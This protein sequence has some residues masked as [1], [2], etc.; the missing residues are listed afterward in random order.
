[1]RRLA[2]IASATI[3]VGAVCAAP[4]AR[5]H[6]LVAPKIDRLHVSRN[7]V[8]IAVDYAVEPAKAGEMRAIFD[9]DADGAITG[10]ERDAAQAWLR[11]AA[12]AFLS[13]NVDGRKLELRE[14]EVKFRGLDAKAGD[15]GGVFVL[16]SPLSL[17]PGVHTLE[18]ADRHK[19]ERIEVPVRV[20]LG[21]GIVSPGA[22][23]H[24]TLG[25][26]ARSLAIVFTAP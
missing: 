15:L 1:M 26:Q 18:L 8:R 6:D 10:K 25:P 20:T 23:G 22:R 13:V 19:D 16:S 2:A 3:L 21:R 5:A 11:A 9:R 24:H 12:T 17:A 14:I 7:E 4:P